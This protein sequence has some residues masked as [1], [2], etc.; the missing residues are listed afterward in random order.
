MARGLDRRLLYRRWVHAHEEDT[1]REMV[2][3]PAEAKL[4]PS[5]GRAAFELREDG[6]FA[7]SGIGPTDRPDEAAG[8]WRLEDEERI[9][10]GEGAPSGVPRVMRIASLDADRLVIER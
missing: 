10:L 1:D 5:R 8:R 9:V 2:F 4:P 6:T 3:R 7:E